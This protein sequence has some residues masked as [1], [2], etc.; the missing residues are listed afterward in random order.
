MT[1][2]E[3]GE[4]TTVKLK[5][6]IALVLTLLGVGFIA[7]F[8]LL[9]TAHELVV[10]AAAVVGGAAAV[11]SAFFAGWS[12]RDALTQKR[13]DNA[14]ALVQT[15]A[16]MDRAKVRLLIDKEIANKA[17]APQDLHKKIL[18]DHELLA[19]VSS[20]LGQLELVAIAV[21]QQYADEETL[22]YSLSFIAPW[23]YNGLRHYIE[24]TRRID[25]NPELDIELEKVADS[26]KDRKSVLTSK[27][28]PASR[29]LLI[30]GG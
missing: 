20:L 26:W 6:G 21:Q 18:A 13:R 12:V 5:I 17:I 10:F 11:Y 15:F 28:F 4:F 24:E 19:G 27:V 9:P 22:F 3:P 29:G 2:K 1:R 14:F 25:N 16:Q 23:A 8:H 30:A 7:A